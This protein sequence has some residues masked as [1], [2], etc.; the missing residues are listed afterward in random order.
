MQRERVGALA[1]VTARVVHAD[2]RP[3]RQL[4]GEDQIV[5][6]EGLRGPA[7]GEDGHPERDPAGPQR[8]RHHRVETLP[9]YAR[10]PGLA[11][12]DPP[13]E[14]GIVRPAEHRPP[15]GQTARRRRERGVGVGLAEADRRLGRLLGA[16]RVRDPPQHHVHVDRSRDRF[17]PAGHGFEQVHADEVGKPG[18]DQIGEFLGGT[19]HIQGGADTGAR[20]VQQGQPLPRPV[21]LAAVERGGADPAH[22]AGGGIPD[23]PHLGDPGMLTEGGRCR[24][25][26]LVTRR[27]RLLDDP[28][29]GPQKCLVPLVRVLVGVLPRRSDVPPARILG[30]GGHGDRGLSECPLHHLVVVR[31]LGRVRGGGHEERLRLAVPVQR[32]GGVHGEIE[33][34]T[35]LVAEGRRA[36]PLPRTGQGVTGGAGE[37]H[38]GEQIDR[39]AP[40]DLRRAVTQQ[41]ASSFAPARDDAL[42]ADG[43]CG[44]VHRR[45]LRASLNRGASLDRAS[46]VRHIGTVL[47]SPQ[48]ARSGL[49][50]QVGPACRTNAP[51]T[52]RRPP[53]VSASSSA[54]VRGKG[55]RGSCSPTQASTQGV[56]RASLA[57]TASIVPVVEGVRWASCRSNRGSPLPW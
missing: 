28:V 37:S 1:G 27:C 10:A 50:G 23:G 22:P 55:P 12:P 57:L 35:V 33:A 13:H 46:H 48:R 51:K 32:G 38:R 30:E 34:V 19:G 45:S 31:R 3:S 5:L 56:L 49:N 43:G 2:G 26:A 53:A 52:V 44:G 17:L 40:H 15:G 14:V 9:A 20:L 41:S 18:H 54:Y 16:G 4:L 24:R 47:V 39:G 7:P 29:D 8:N 21:L 11:L 25:T 42:W 6:G 36:A